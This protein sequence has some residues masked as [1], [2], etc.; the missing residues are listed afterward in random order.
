MSDPSCVDF[1]KQLLAIKTL[2]CCRLGVVLRHSSL[3]FTHLH[4]EG[5][6]DY[7]PAV[8][9]PAVEGPAVE[10]GHL[11]CTRDADMRRNVFCLSAAER[12]P[13][14]LLPCY[15]SQRV[16]G[17]TDEQRCERMSADG[18]IGRCVNGRVCTLALHPSG[19][20]KLPSLNAAFHRHD[21]CQNA[22]CSSNGQ[23]KR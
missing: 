22:F 21:E 5:C 15:D 16:C 3:S 1:N 7:G 19:A 14:I 2:Y 10:A 12:R 9:G 18:Q 23:F 8:E 20:D 11:C 6:R 17:E 4:C 13:P